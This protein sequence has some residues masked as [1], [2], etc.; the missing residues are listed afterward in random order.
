MFLI[1]FF[2]LFAL[3]ASLHAD[4]VT[5]VW[6]ANSETDL[7]GYRLYQA[8]VINGTSTQWEMVAEILAGTETYTVTIDGSKDYAWQ[9]TAYDTEG[10]ESFV[11]NMTERI[12]Q[13]DWIPPGRAKN[14]REK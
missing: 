14:L 12:R 7:A 11:S 6:D 2:V 9:L 3:C 13:V 4:V 8:Q 10:N 1:F 5:L